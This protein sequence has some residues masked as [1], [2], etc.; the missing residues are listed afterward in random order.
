MSFIY[1]F[2]TNMSDDQI[3]NEALP[4]T[5][6]G[7]SAAFCLADNVRASAVAPTRDE[8]EDEDRAIAASQQLV[9]QECERLGMESRVIVCDGYSDI[10]RSVGNGEYVVWGRM[11]VDDQFVNHDIATISDP[12][13]LDLL[14]AM[15]RTLLETGDWHVFFEDVRVN[16]E[17]RRIEIELG[18]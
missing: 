15:N 6:G 11:V 4:L 2:D 18:S 14:M 13:L 12:T 7:H 17:T 9:D 16:N 3:P 1:F 5:P 8:E 10:N